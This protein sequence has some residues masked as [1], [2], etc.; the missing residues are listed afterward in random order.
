MFSLYYSIPDK[1]IASN[2]PCSHLYV[3]LFSVYVATRWAWCWSHDLFVKR[4][5]SFNHVVSSAPQAIMNVVC[6]NI[7]VAILNI[8]Q[9]DWLMLHIQRNTVYIQRNTV[10]I[11]YQQK[12]FGKMFILYTWYNSS[13]NIDYWTNQ[14]LA[15]HVDN[16][17][18]WHR[19][20][21]RTQILSHAVIANRMY[22]LCGTFI[23]FPHIY[24]NAFLLCVFVTL[25]S[26]FR[27]ASSTRFSIIP[28]SV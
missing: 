26:F 19:H 12:H 7:S 22:H 17:F 21:E 27:Y 25:V 10:Y 8:L 18:L 6:V 2:F 23:G 5:C 15:Y 1:C 24:D 3:R 28:L 16:S 4:L 20:H 11:Q 9:T 13:C 14:N